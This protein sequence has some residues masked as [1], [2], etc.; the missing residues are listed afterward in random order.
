[1]FANLRSCQ[2]P[3]PPQNLL[4]GRDIESELGIDMRA[5][6][7]EERQ[8]QFVGYRLQERMFLDYKEEVNEATVQYVGGG[9]GP[10]KA[11]D[12]LP[13]QTYS[14]YHSDVSI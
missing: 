13:I 7:R 8:V 12:I 5:C 10:P 2:K 9:F 1:M 6:L 11:E 4:H 3:T 14:K